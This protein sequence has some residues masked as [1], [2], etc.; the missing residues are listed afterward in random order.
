MEITP[1]ETIPIE[2]QHVASAT[3]HRPDVEHEQ[4]V[5]MDPSLKTEPETAMTW[6]QLFDHRSDLQ[7]PDIMCRTV[8]Y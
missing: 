5:L 7:R 2:A 8:T 6:Q 4:E 3:S 1:Q